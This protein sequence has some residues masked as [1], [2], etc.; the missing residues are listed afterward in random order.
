MQLLQLLL[1]LFTANLVFAKA[2]GTSTL[3]IATK[4]KSDLIGTALTVTVFTT[5]GSGIGWF[6]HAALPERAAYFLPLCYVLVLAALYVLLLLLLQA[7]GQR[8]F[9][10]FRKYLHL[11]AFNCVV[12]GTLLLSSEVGGGWLDAMRFGLESGIGFLAACCMLKAV[13]PKLISPR[14]PASVQGYPAILLYIGILS[15]AVYTLQK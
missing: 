7:A 4:S 2:L 13:Y 14:V 5:L 3:S 1:T 8:F 11:S 12:L 10:R 6:V 15:M 9:L